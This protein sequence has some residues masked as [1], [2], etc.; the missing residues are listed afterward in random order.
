M[1]E[2]GRVYFA[3]FKELLG[4]LEEAAVKGV[5]RGKHPSLLPAT[6]DV[7]KKTWSCATS[8]DAASPVTLEAAEIS[9]LQL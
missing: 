7:E 8:R 9:R 1:S 3:K 6:F 4:P 5:N 2:A